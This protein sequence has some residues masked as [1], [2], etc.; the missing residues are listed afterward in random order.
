MSTGHHVSTGH[1][2]DYSVA[3]AHDCVVQI[4]ENGPDCTHWLIVRTGAVE[5]KIALDLSAL[6]TL[7]KAVS[8]H[9]IF[10]RMSIEENP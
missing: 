9:P 6:M 7:C 4:V 2:S 5:Q 1:K 10:K 3:Y 8:I